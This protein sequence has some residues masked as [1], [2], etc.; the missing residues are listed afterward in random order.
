MTW[1]NRADEL[2]VYWLEGDALLASIA[3]VSTVQSKT[4]MWQTY[5]KLDIFDCM[6]FE[7]MGPISMAVKG[8]N[9][10]I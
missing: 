7:T 6:V 10:H 1:K 9:W 4:K 8:K 2:E 5:Q 3:K